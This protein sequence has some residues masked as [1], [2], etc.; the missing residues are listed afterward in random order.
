MCHRCQQS[1]NILS[2]ADNDDTICHLW[3][4]G[5]HIALRFSEVRTLDKGNE[6]NLRTME[7]LQEKQRIN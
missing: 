7:E 4:L 1:V 6:R 2:I 3:L 5:T